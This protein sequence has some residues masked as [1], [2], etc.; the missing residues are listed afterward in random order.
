[1]KQGIL[2]KGAALIVSPLAMFMEVDRQA[3]RF[4]STAAL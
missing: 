3:V 1:M 2:D 4:A